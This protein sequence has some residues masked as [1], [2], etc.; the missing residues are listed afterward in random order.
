M[1][2]HQDKHNALSRQN[3]S[4]VGVLN[5]ESS[6]HSQ[7]NLSILYINTTHYAGRCYGSGHSRVQ[8]LLTSALATCVLMAVPAGHDIKM[9]WSKIVSGMGMITDEVSSDNIA[10]CYDVD[11]DVTRPSSD[12]EAGS[13][14]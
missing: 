2:R 11:H 6:I 13:S 12:R 14:E 3:N 9:S 7:V 10:Q 4:V 1:T 5:L 8:V